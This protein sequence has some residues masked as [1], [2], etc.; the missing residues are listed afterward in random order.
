MQTFQAEPNRG[1]RGY[2]LLELLAVTAIISIVL[3]A[4]PKVYARLMP[5]V[6]VRQFVSTIV[7]EAKGLRLKSRQDRTIEI[8]TVFNGTN[9]VGVDGEIW[10][11]PEG[12]I[13]TYEPHAM[14]QAA[15]AQ[16]IEFYPDGTNSGGELSFVYRNIDIQLELDWVS[17]A[18]E[19][20]R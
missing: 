5:N 16:T 3:A 4:T 15:T 2:T 20:E 9:S 10:S 7:A 18:V 6:Q 13:I 19:V 12:L 1:D 8:L 17:G 11:G 14:S